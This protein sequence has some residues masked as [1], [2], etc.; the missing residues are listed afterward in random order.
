MSLT[1]IMS[2]MQLSQYPVVALVIFLAAFA[3]VLV[4]VTFR[5]RGEIKHAA[6]LPLND[7]TEAAINPGKSHATPVSTEGTNS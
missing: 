2:H 1:D 6:E 7:G 4:Q 3:S 5:S